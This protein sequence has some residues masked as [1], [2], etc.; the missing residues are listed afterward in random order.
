MRR[1]Q[2]KE[3]GGERGPVHAQ[4]PPARFRLCSSAAERGGIAS[5]AIC[6]QSLR[7]RRGTTWRAASPRP[8]GQGRAERRIHLAQ[9]REVGQRADLGGLVEHEGDGPAIHGVEGGPGGQQGQDGTAAFRRPPREN[10]SASRARAGRPAVQSPP[11]A[12]PG[13][14]G[15][16]ARETWPRRGGRD[17]RAA[18]LRSSVGVHGRVQEGGL[19][20]AGRAREEEEGGPARLRFTSESSSPRSE[21]RAHRGSTNGCARRAPAPPRARVDSRRPAWRMTPVPGSVV[22]TRCRRAAAV[23]R[24]V[25]HHHHARVDGVAHADAA[26]VM[27]RDPGRP[28][29]PR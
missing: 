18:I 29:R 17:R 4:P 24:A 6:G 11:A 5:V 23:V 14:I 15:R 25:R 13:R 28:R 9:A 21:H 1:G 16:S 27:D 2:P 8:R 22:R 26:P 7:P 20:R 10:W 3:G 12:R 19:A